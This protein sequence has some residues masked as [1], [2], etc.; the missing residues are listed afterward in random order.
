MSQSKKLSSQVKIA[1]KAKNKQVRVYCEGEATENNYLIH[2]YRRY[3]DRIIVSIAEHGET[4]PLQIVQRAAREKKRDEKE[5][6]RGKGDAFDEY[7]CVFDVDEHPFV[8]EA[9]QTAR[10]NGIHIALSNPCLELWF[11]LHFDNQ[12]AWIH[13]HDAQKCSEGHLGCKKRLTPAALTAL[14]EKIEHAKKR[15]IE[16][17]KKHLL[18]GTTLP[19][20]PSTGMWKLIDEIRGVSQ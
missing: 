6:S 7:W 12:Q 2:W 18:D 10:D 16:L 19:A 15:A 5:Q 11:M 8:P 13:R 1:A 3:R 4:S 17:D 20:N 14:D 9:L